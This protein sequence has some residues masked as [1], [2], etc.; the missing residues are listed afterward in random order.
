MEC[1]EGALKALGHVRQTGGSKKH[2]LLL[3]VL[4]LFVGSLIEMIVD[5]VIDLVEFVKKK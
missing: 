3:Y 2:V 1:S 4:R 5:P